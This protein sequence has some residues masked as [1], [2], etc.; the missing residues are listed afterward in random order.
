MCV[1][2]DNKRKLAILLGKAKEV[3]VKPKQ[4]NAEKEA[5]LHTSK[6]NATQIFGN[7]I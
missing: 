5:I 6:M 7:K 1:K 2:K 4:E 3:M